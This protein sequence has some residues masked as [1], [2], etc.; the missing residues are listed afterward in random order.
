MIV[1]KDVHKRYK[2]KHGMG[3]WVLTGVSFVIPKNVNVGLIG[4]NGAGKSTLLRIIAGVDEPTRGTVER[5]CR[6]SWPMGLA[7]GLQPLM[8]GR[9]N[10]K[11][12]CRIHGQEDDVAERLAAIQEFAEIGAAFDEPISTYSSGMKARLKFAI[13]VAFDFEVYISDE[14]TAVGDRAFKQ[15]AKQTFAD[16]VDRAGLIMVSHQEGVLQ[17]F[18][19]AGILL[20]DGGAQWYDD[21]SEAMKVYEA[22]Q[23]AS[24][25]KP[26]H[27]ARHDLSQL[28]EQGRA[29]NP[30]L[31]THRTGKRLIDEAKER[32][33]RLLSERQLNKQGLALPSNA[34]P[35]LRKHTRAGGEKV[36]DLFD[37]SEFNT[38]PEKQE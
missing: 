30:A 29:G 12:A 32:G 28:L 31:V 20:A 22:S 9:Q 4:A 11:F 7:G 23:D 27:I 6:V 37:L 21:I 33:V 16:L 18:C 35:L 17:E 3:P 34:M 13:S 24:C 15:K 1:V 36:V 2:T 8:T 19:Q 10:A 26:M 5:H 14:L 38:A 25:Y